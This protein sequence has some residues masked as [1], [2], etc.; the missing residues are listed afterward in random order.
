MR[1]KEEAHDYRYFPEPDL[2][3]LIVRPEWIDEIRSALPELPEQL[4]AR[5]V[6]A[7]ALTPYDADVIVRLGK[8]AEYFE[9]MVRR[10]APAKAA[11]NWIQG[12]VR[13]KL[14]ETGAEDVSAVP[15]A[16]DALA[17]LVM[18]TDKGVINSSAAKDVLEK[19]WTTGR[20]A[21]AIVDEEGLGQIGDEQALAAIV[22]DVVANNPDPVAQFRGGKANA[23]GFLVGQVMKI[24]AGK[25]NP[26]LVNELLRRA[27]GG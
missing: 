9:A 16:P 1:S 7:Y 13:R 20:R 6:A 3:P 23:L 5:L 19:M 17:E 2:P 10:G 11:S 12:E 8:A 26:K 14:K 27:I 4:K 18:L 25:A 22:A 15:F 21:Q 24:S